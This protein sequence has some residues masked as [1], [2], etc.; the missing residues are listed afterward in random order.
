MSQAGAHAA[1]GGFGVYAGIRD[2]FHMADHAGYFCVNPV[3]PI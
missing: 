2:G 3:L 1:D